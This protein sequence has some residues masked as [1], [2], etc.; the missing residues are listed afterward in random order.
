M[1][2]PAAEVLRRAER[3]RVIVAAGLAVV[4]FLAGCGSSQPPSAAVPTADQTGF[5]ANYANLRAG[6]DGEPTYVYRM[7]GS[8]A[9]KYDK[10]ILDA[11]EVWR[12]DEAQDQ[13]L[14]RDA[15]QFLADYLY[16]QLYMRL[17]RDYEMVDVADQTTM[18]VR[19][20]YT[21]VNQTNTR[22]DVESSRVP[23]PNLIP[24]FKR[25]TEEAPPPRLSGGTSVEVAIRDAQ[26][27][28]TFFAGIERKDLASPTAT[29]TGGTI[30]RRSSS[31]TRTGSRTRSVASAS[32]PRA[33]AAPARSAAAR[34][35]PAATAAPWSFRASPRTR[36][37]VPPAMSLVHGRP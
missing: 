9:G 36:R 19:V 15:V 22:L 6:K 7:E 14:S 23:R 21:N 10:I 30:W 17:D 1:A 29:A 28:V 34:T 5:L 25:E 31:T 24:Q 13:G 26:S 11:V 32:D 16:T 20:A 3:S 18:R 4:P 33:R 12:G 37:A 35:T 2:A 8:K 27:N